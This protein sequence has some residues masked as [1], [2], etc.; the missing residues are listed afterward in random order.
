[1]ITTDL[2]PPLAGII[3]HGRQI[4]AVFRH[5]GFI[6]DTPE[7]GT[8][9]RADDIHTLLGLPHPPT[10]IT[11]L[12]QGCVSPTIPGVDDA[13]RETTEPLVPGAAPAD[14][15]ATSQPPEPYSEEQPR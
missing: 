4:R 1:M 11:R 14:L 8:A 3:A 2:R 6:P 7:G 9:P 13:L 12:A 15:A 5:P 10:L